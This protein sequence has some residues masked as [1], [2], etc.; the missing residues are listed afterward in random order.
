[1][2][3]IYEYRVG[4]NFVPCIGPS[5]CTPQKSAAGRQSGTKPQNRWPGPARRGHGPARPINF[6]ARPGPRTKIGPGYKFCL[7]GWVGKSWTG[8]DGPGRWAG[9]PVGGR[10]GPWAGP[11]GP[12]RLGRAA[13]ARPGRM[14]RPVPL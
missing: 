8:R 3:R 11:H 7:H 2:R 6:S 1:M 10:P 9:P 12:G 4:M 14:G 13:R 5:R